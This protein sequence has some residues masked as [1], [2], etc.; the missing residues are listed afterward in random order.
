MGLLDQLVGALG[1][2]NGRNTLGELE[3]VWNWVQEQGGV[4]VLLNKF[5]QGGLGEIL[6][7]WIGNGSNQS[8]SG[9]EIKSAFGEEALQSLA[10]KLGTD[11]NGASGTLADLLPHLID[12]LSPQGEVDAQ[13][14][15][16]KP[17]DLGSMVD[18][19]FKR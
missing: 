8:V 4:E 11:I 7:S 13:A 6:A 9:G 16:N 10:Q 15:Q 19:L 12:R 17:F 3:A 1:N 2:G 18:Q 14:V 5:Q